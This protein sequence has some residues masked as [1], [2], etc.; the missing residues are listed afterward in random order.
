M[1]RGN[2]ASP[3][4]DYRSILFTRHAN[5][6]DSLSDVGTT[7]MHARRP[8]PQLAALPDFNL[9]GPV[10]LPS[11]SGL[12]IAVAVEAVESEAVQMPGRREIAD[13]TREISG[14]RR[15]RTRVVSL[16]PPRFRT[17]R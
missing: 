13:L 4:E 7:R 12:A 9:Y 17:R 16:P 15:H 1:A 8:G 3:I 6:F 14:P 5:P 2:R 11:P 10:T